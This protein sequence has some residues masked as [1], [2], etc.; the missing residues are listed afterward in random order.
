MAPDG[1]GR[2]HHA[3]QKGVGVALEDVSVLERARLPLVG[4]DHQILGLWAGLRD[5][6][7]LSRGRKSSPA[8][9]AEVGPGDLV[10]DLRRRHREKRLPGRDVASS[11]DVGVPPRPVWI[12]ESGR[13]H[14]SVSGH[15]RLRLEG[16]GRATG[17]A[18]APPA[19]W[20]PG[21][22]LRLKGPTNCSSSCAMGAISH[23]HRHSTS[24]SVNSPPGGRLAWA[25][26]QAI[27]ELGEHILCSPQHAGQA[28]AD[29]KLAPARRFCAEHRVEG[30]HLPYV[31]DSHA[32]ETSHPELSVRGDMA[33]VLLHQP[34]QG[35]HG[36]PRLVVALDDLPGLWFER[37]EV[38]RS[39]SPPIML[40]DPNV[41]V[42]SA[43]MS[44]M[45]SLGRADMMAKQ[46]GRT[47]TRYGLLVPSLTT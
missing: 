19:A 28:R 24:V 42:T 10:D 17:L 23:A 29:A 12:L 26:V 1:I 32:H 13:E 5:E 40:T 4:V 39:S 20:R 33:E 36:R 3:F 34:Q 16:L 22:P 27:L 25:D 6:G 37:C 35:Q 7:P 44:P 30:N 15:K 21:F 2:D 45:M 11:R 38:H 43:I 41:G 18:R 14:R 9:T 47:R 31:G 46:G 8:Q